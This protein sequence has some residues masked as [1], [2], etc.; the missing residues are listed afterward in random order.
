MDLLL[1]KLEKTKSKNKEILITL[2]RHLFDY[3]IITRI[4]NEQDSQLDLKYCRYC[5]CDHGLPDEIKNL[6]IEIRRKL[7]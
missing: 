7:K 5:E 3:K 6:I 4:R 2:V 1:V